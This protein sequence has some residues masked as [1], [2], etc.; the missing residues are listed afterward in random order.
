MSLATNAIAALFAGTQAH[1]EKIRPDGR[2]IHDGL[3]VL[4]DAESGQPVCT[5][6]A[7]EITHKI[8]GS[9]RAAC[10][11]AITFKGDEMNVPQLLAHRGI[12][13]QVSVTPF[14]RVAQAG[15]TR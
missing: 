9:T 12:R 5:A 11:R 6:D 14:E 13:P 7:G 1:G 15:G 8:C 3:V 4:F 2:R 10:M